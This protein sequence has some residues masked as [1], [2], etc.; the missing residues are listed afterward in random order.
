MFS[1]LLRPGLMVWTWATDAGEGAEFGLG[2]A[3]VA[4]TGAGLVHLR[5]RRVRHSVIDAK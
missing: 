1:A 4:A 5:R 3:A 2:A